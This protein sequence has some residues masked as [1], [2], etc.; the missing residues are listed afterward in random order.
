MMTST[1]FVC[2]L[3]GPL[4]ALT[5][6]LT[7]GAQAQAQEV[8]PEL[9]LGSRVTSSL[10]VGNNLGPTVSFADS[11]LLLRGRLDLFHAGY[12]GLL[13]GFQFPDADSDLG[14]VFFNQINVFVQLEYVDVKLGRTR[15]QTSIIDFPTFRDDDLLVFTNVLNPFS[16]GRNTEEHQY[17]NTAEVTL[18]FD[19]RWFASLHAEQM[20]RANPP[21]GLDD[22][23]LNSYG[24]TLRYDE[25]PGRADER[26]VRSAGLGFNAIDVSTGNEEMLF[27]VLAGF[28]V[29]LHPDPIHLVELRGQAVYSHGLQGIVVRD[30]TSSYRARYVSAAL[31]LR[32]LWSKEMIPTLQVSLVGGLQRFLNDDGQRVG[33]LVNGFY[34]LG[35]GFDLGLQYRVESADRAL[36]AALGS[37]ALDHRAEVLLMFEFDAVSGSLGDRRSV[38]N[39]EHGYLP[40]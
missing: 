7:C 21:F 2:R 37:P 24:V 10:G 28:S 6:I 5:L 30:D 32:Y 11:M 26:V 39:A 40:N 29:N 25:I 20:L 16:A 22:F 23:S 36:R 31:S 15:A 1:R 14:L 3:A 12:G 34:R 13:L 27:N 19:N 17:A 35:A 33:G 4:T 38:L 8:T 18:H 9:T